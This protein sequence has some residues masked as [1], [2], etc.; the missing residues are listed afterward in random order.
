MASGNPENE[1]RLVAITRPGVFELRRSPVPSLHA[2]AVR[3]IDTSTNG[4]LEISG[5]IAAAWSQT[6]SLTW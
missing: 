6:R 2:D 5:I 3:A 1:E 4:A